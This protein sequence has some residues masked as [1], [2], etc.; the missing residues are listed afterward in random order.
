MFFKNL[1]TLT[2]INRGLLAVSFLLFAHHSYAFDVSINASGKAVSVFS[3][4]AQ[5]KYLSFTAW[6][7]NGQEVFAETSNG[8]KVV[9]AIES[10]L[11]STVRQSHTILKEAV[12]GSRCSAAVTSPYL[13]GH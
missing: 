11:A 9:W 5:V 7:M 3:N 8:A 13:R 1:S 6:S 12:S 2:T 10:E 4:D